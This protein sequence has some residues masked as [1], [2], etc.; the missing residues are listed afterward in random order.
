MKGDNEK[1]QRL[2][3]A[4]HGKLS[5]DTAMIAMRRVVKLMADMKDFGVE[6]TK[7]DTFDNRPE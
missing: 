2:G 1:F 3:N 6:E 4:A 7:P 5:K